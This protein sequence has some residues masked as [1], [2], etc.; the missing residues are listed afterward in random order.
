MTPLD[1]NNIRRVHCIGI[2]GIGLSALARLL[3]HEGKEVTGYDRS[4]SPVTD[5]LRSEGFA[6]TINHDAA[7]LLGGIDLAIYSDAVP[8][9]HSERIRVRELGIPELSYFEALG[10]LT[11]RYKLIAVAGSHGKT[12]TTAMLVDIFE[13]AGLDPT[14]VVG[15]LRAKTKSNYRAGEGEYFIAE[16]D[17]WKRHFLQ[18]SPYIVAITNIDADHLDYYRDIGDI[19]DAFRELALKIPEDGFLVC[20]PNHTLLQPVIKDLRCFVVDYRDYYDEDLPLRVLPFNHVNAATALAVAHVAGIE[21][22][23]ARRALSSFT[24]TWRR[25]EY[26]GE[27]PEGA[28]VYDDYAHHPTEIA[29]TLASAREQFPGRKIFVAFHPH[30]YSRTKKL[31]AEFA[32]AFDAADDIVVAPIFAARETPVPSI[33]NE[34]LAERIRGEG[35]DARALPSF[36]EIEAY[37]RAAAR[38][39]DIV[40]TMGAGD[41]YKVGENLVKKDAR[42]EV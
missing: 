17:E 19:Q 23:V 24:G 11:R 37:L 8:P 13:A 32:R 1:W 20:D 36:E 18:F 3:K 12:T 39:G 38:Q 28:S 15:S 41:I 9:D 40:I 6:I 14:A 34:V 10:Q 22:E 4:A 7:P 35:K 30:L 27:T 33:S 2:G 31:L 5:A 26:K 25:F 21:T 16:A 42:L 29:V